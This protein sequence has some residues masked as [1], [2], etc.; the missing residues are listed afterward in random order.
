MHGVWA[1]LGGIHRD[2]RADLSADIGTASDLTR[3]SPP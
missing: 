2:Q 1:Y 3:P